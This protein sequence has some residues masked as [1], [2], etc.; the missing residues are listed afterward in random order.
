MSQQQQGNVPEAKKSPTVKEIFQASVDDAS[1]VLENTDTVSGTPRL[2]A[3]GALLGVCIVFLAAL[4]GLSKL[5]TP[6]TIALF[7][8]S[9]ATPLL[10]CGVLYPTGCATRLLLA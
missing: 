10:T 9:L 5:D 3:E 6:L 2:I 1:R 4:I 8:F 7:A